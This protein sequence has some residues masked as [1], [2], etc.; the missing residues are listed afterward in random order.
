MKDL[1][2]GEITP[3]LPHDEYTEQADKAREAELKA[4]AKP[5]A[6]KHAKGEEKG[7]GKTADKK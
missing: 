2:T 6:K 7:D 5:E 3:P 1:K 4:R